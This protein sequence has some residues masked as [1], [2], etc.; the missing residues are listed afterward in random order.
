MHTNPLIGTGYESFWLGP[1][2]LKVWQGGLGG[3]NEAH[4]G[5]LEFY[6]NLGLIGVGLLVWFLTSSYRTIC[7]RFKSSPPFASLGLAVWTVL[8]FHC[9]TEADFRGGLLWLTLLMVG[10]A[11]PLRMEA[12]SRKIAIVNPANSASLQSDYFLETM[13]QWRRL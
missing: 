13:S 6:L 10:V 1:R 9:V 11:L 3:I 5:Y 12:R 2:L 7:K 8:L 4:N